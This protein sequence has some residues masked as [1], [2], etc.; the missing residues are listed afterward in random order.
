M[1]VQLWLRRWGSSCT[2]HSIRQYP[3]RCNR[4]T[5]RFD[6]SAWISLCTT[7]GMK[8][9]CGRSVLWTFQKSFSHRFCTANSWNS[10][11]IC[12]LP[13]LVFRSIGINTTKYRPWVI[14][15][16]DPNTTVV[17]CSIDPNTTVVLCSINPNTTVA[18]WINGVVL[19]LYWCS[20]R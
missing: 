5:H 12:K 16:I 1:T 14:R 20:N 10:P 9:H 19:L 11:F 17:L 3:A 13:Q 15:S 2:M 4:S 6:H 18:I 8:P 7:L